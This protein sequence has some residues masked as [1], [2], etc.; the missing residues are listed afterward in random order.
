[1]RAERAE[2]GHGALARARHG[3]H[4]EHAGR[5]AADPGAAA[6]A[7]APARLA[8]AGAAG[9]AGSAYDGPDRPVADGAGDD[10]AGH[11]TGATAGGDG[12]RHDAACAA[13]AVRAGPGPHLDADFA[14][15]LH[16]V[17]SGGAR[18]RAHAPG[19]RIAV[20]DAGPRG[21]G[22]PAVPEPARAG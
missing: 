6:G 4:D 9:A 5:A 7:G 12:A 20:L 13:L 22:K 21:A 11:G 18:P 10:A 1:E 3:S 16:A 15:R 14:D 19:P 2:D 8:H 17:G